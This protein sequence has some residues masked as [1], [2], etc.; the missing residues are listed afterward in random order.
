MSTPELTA[1]RGLRDSVAWCVLRVT[2]DE[3]AVAAYIYVSPDG[4]GAQVAGMYPCDPTDVDGMINLDF[5]A[6]GRLVGV[7]VLD[8]RAKLVQELLAAAED[9]T[10]CAT[11]S[12]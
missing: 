6:A 12:Q 8:A 10:K 2:Y 1:I 7:E 4:E 5:D 3:E 9:I 11:D